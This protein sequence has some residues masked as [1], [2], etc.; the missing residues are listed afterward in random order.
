MD[1]VKS[2]SMELLRLVFSRNGIQ[3]LFGFGSLTAIGI[4]CWWERPS[5]ALIVV[6]GLLLSGIVYARTRG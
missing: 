6:G 3:S 4:G 1:A 5:L 2:V